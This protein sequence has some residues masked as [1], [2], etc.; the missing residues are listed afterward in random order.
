MADTADY[1][2]EMFDRIMAINL[3]GVAL[4]KYEIPQMLNIGGGAMVNTA[5]GAGLVGVAQLSAYNA[6]KHGVVG[7]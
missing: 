4:Y 2:E 6:S 3:K 5:S 7:D 1:P